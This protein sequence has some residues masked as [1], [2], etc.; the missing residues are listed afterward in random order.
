[1]MTKCLHVNKDTYLNKFYQYKLMNINCDI[2]QKNYASYKTLWYHKK[3]KHQQVIVINEK[4]KPINNEKKKP[5]NNEK[6]IIVEDNI[7]LID[8]NSINNKKDIIV[9][10]NNI[11]IDEKT[12]KIIKDEYRCEY[13]LKTYKT[14]QSKS[15][16]KKTCNVK[17]GGATNVQEINDL[18][19]DLQTKIKDLEKNNGAKNIININNGTINNQT[20]NKIIIN[21]IGEENPFELK[22]NQIQKVLSQ[23]LISIITLIEYL[24]FNE[25][26]PSNHNF[27]TSSLESNYLTIYNSDENTFEKQRKKYV[28]DEVMES[29]ISKV[30]KLYEVFKNDFPQERQNEFKNNIDALKQIH[31]AGYSNKLLKELNKQLN[32][33]SYNKKHIVEK[34]WSRLRNDPID[35]EEDKKYWLELASENQ[36]DMN[37]NSNYEPEF[38]FIKEEDSDIE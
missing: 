17:K 16:H 26:L 3:T 1:M 32:L 12:N 19:N 27:L 28:F 36:S 11:L 4:N 9:E 6:D 7:M 25:Q 20:N 29:S 30:E 14:R 34:T 23:E 5:I 24:N 13:C 33:L 22:L 10:D 15:R 37:T 31:Q 35:E 21:K 18:I 2:C 38:K 8:E